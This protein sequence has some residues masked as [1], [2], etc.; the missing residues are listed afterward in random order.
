MHGVYVHIHLPDWGKW[1]KTNLSVS[2]SMHVCI[3]V[4]AGSEFSST[5]YLS[6]ITHSHRLKP[7]NG[8]VLFALQ[9]GCHPYTINSMSIS[10][11]QMSW[12]RCTQLRSRLEALTKLM[13]EMAAETALV[14]HACVQG[15]MPETCC[16]CKGAQATRYYRR[17]DVL[18]ITQFLSRL[19]NMNNASPNIFKFK[20]G[21]F[22]FN[23]TPILHLWLEVQP[24][25]KVKCST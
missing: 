6:Q 24:L 22:L 14:L 4:A 7:S 5:F 25:G 8:T 13:N 3:F 18:T 19:W 2:L 10:G 20:W 16:I 9:Q 11:Q 23:S 21:R 15:S 12:A 1:L 17:W